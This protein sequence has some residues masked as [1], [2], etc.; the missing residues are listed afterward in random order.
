MLW[1]PLDFWYKSTVNA[2]NTTVLKEKKIKS[3]SESPPVNHSTFTSKLTC[4]SFQVCD[5]IGSN[6]YTVMEP[7]F[8][9][10]RIPMIHWPQ[11]QS[12]DHN[13]VTVWLTFCLHPGSHRKVKIILFFQSLILYIHLKLCDNDFWIEF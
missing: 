6:Q 9:V 1:D 3:L 10:K 8:A 5:P 7:L 13:T 11:S 2:S 12:S 4:S